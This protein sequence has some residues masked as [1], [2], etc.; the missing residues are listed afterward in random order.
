MNN[1][2]A[3]ILI[4]DYMK[5]GRVLENVRT[6]LAQRVDFDFKVVVIDNSVNVENATTLSQIN[7]PQVELVINNKNFGYTRAHNDVGHMIEG[8]YLLIVNPDIE[9]REVDAL[10]KMIDYMEAH[11]EVAVLGPKQIEESGEVA[12]SI[13]AFPKLYVQMSRRTWLRNMPF[14][15][16]KV[17]HDEMRHLDYNKTQEVD[18]L[19]SSCVVV[20]KSFW[21]EIGGLNEKYFLFMSDVELCYDAWQ[22]G[23]KVVY[24]PEVKVYADGKRVSAGGFK[25]FF[26]SWVL[27][28]HLKDALRYRLKHFF[29]PNPRQDSEVKN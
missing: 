10:Q 6:L 24:F 12:M 13:R 26:K 21:D 7:D 4:L 16:S 8:E 17:A 23:Y 3:T 29:R 18:W 14:L 19:Q 5:A 20:R 11:N 25:T 1:K 27:R 22:K 15:K 28:Q 2:K 9:W